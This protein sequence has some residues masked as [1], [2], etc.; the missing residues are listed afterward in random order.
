MDGRKKSKSPVENC[1]LSHPSI[2]G[3][4]DPLGDLQDF[5]GFWNHRRKY[6]VSNGVTSHDSMAPQGGQMEMWDLLVVWVF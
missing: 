2:A 6:F 3:F 4:N 1:G 5:D